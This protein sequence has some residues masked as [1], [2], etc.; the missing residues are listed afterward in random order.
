MLAARRYFISHSSREKPL[1]MAVAQLLR[2]DAWVDLYEVDLGDVLLEKIARAIQDATDFVLLWS[3]DSTESRWVGF[4]FHMA[5]VRWLEDRAINLRI[6]N[7]DGCPVPLYFR[8]FLQHRG[9]SANEIAAALQEDPASPP[10][11]RAFINRNSEIESI[12]KWSYDPSVYAVWLWGLA[13]IGKR[14]LAS[15]AASRI[16]ASREQIKKVQIEAGTREVELNLLISSR[17]GTPAAPEDSN[18]AAVFDN[19]LTKIGDFATAEG[20]WIFEDAQHW[21]NDDAS[22][23]DIAE[24]LLRRLVSLPGDAHNRLIIFTST[25]QPLIPPLLDSVVRKQRI[26]GLQRDHG[27]ALLEAHGAAGSRDDLQRVVEQLGGHP[28]AL[29][30]AAR[31]LPTS[32][33]DF[34]EQRSTLA[35]E[36]V[37]DA[38]LRDETWRLLEVLA[39]VGGPLPGESIAAHLLLSGT[40]F[41][42][43]VA[44]AESYGLVEEGDSGYLRLHPLVSD[45]F[46][47]SFR[48]RDDSRQR[49]SDLADRSR[50]FLQ[51]THPSTEIRVETL[52][53]TFR[54]LGQAL[55]LNEALALRSDLIG[56]LFETAKQLYRN[57][58]YADAVRYT[59]EVLKTVPDSVDALLL[60]ARCFAYLGRLPEARDIAEKVLEAQPNDAWVLRVRGRI[61]FIAREWQAAETFFLQG[62]RIRKRS[63]QLLLDLC[64]VRIRRGDW[65]G[66]RAAINEATAL[67]EGSGF[68]ANL[69]SQILEHFGDYEAAANMMQRALRR[70]PRNATYHHRL[71]RIS[72]LR[73]DKSAARSRYARAVELDPRH[74]ESWLSLASVSADLGQFDAAREALS[75]ARKL[76]QARKPVIHTIAA[77]MALLQDDL[78][79]AYAEIQRALD[80]D[81]ELPALTLGIRITLARFAAAEID[82]GIARATVLRLAKQIGDL[83]FVDDALD[84]RRSIDA[85]CHDS[86]E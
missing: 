42:Q 46:S 40:S 32:E 24:G 65:T 44:E 12:E 47:R 62:L 3:S 22:L 51:Q 30:M 55:R 11:R 61:E 4:E 6:V 39:A 86:A 9:D 80:A 29:E 5:F 84:A 56:T 16:V 2:R 27:V 66:A 13:G 31:N 58:D 34:E 1:A 33:A 7:V 36:L 85:V 71:G 53:S 81:P 83:G 20:I 8:P 67:G 57:R 72:E 54:L 14:T 48:R 21:L 77:K 73:G 60:K 59:D 19:T 69:H 70:D 41:G 15:N 75:K 35:A 28:L 45:F 25:R 78:G 79:A 23:S 52:L 64:D 50:A 10:R 68:A 17:L 26:S 63:P 37:G 82:C 38:N 18:V 43:A 49:L 76:S 74:A